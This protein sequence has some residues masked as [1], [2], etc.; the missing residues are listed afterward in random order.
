MAERKV[1]YQR[2]DGASSGFTLK[3]PTL[4][5]LFIDAGLALTDSWTKQDF[6]ADLER[7]AIALRAANFQTLLVLWLN[8][9]IRLAAQEKFLAKRIVFEKFDGTT[10]TAAL[11][12]E[13]HS[14]PK[15][16][17]L[18]P[19]AAIQPNNVLIEMQTDGFNH[20]ALRVVTG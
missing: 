4:E 15:H 6:I 1:T 16:G 2:L 3:A 7:R 11:F 17:H 13:L 20:F 14:P 12:G 18:T 5:R 8:E 9:L 10:L 19:P